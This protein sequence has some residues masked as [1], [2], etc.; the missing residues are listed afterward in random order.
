MEKRAV[1][2]CG[3]FEKREPSVSSFEGLADKILSQ[4]EMWA[5]FSNMT[6][7]VA[8]FRVL[9]V[10]TVDCERGFSA[11][12]LLKIRLRCRMGFENLDHLMC[13]DINFPGLSEF[14]PEVIYQKWRSLKKRQIFCSNNKLEK[15][16]NM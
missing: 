4:E 5:K 3:L 12:N 9:L 16:I 1:A 13:V 14:E 15:L 11:Q 8:I 2:N 6:G 7:L 10:S